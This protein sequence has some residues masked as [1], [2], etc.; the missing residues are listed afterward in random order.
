MNWFKKVTVEE[1]LFLLVFL[2]LENMFTFKKRVKVS[3]LFPVA[4]GAASTNFPIQKLF[5]PEKAGGGVEE[6]SDH[7][8]F[9]KFGRWRERG[10]RREGGGER[11]VPWRE[12]EG[13]L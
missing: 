2:S 4:G 5:S 1:K 3:R 13:S 9:H 8:P 7:S 12:A 6:Y 10:N 11:G